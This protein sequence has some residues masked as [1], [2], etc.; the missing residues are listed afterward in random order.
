MNELELF[1]N[2]L[3]EKEVDKILIR[4]KNSSKN[5]NL[6]FKKIKLRQIFRK[7][8]TKTRKSLKNPFEYTLNKYK[9]SDYQK[10]SEKEFFQLMAN[11]ENSKI[12][13]YAR[14]ANALIY[15]NK[16]TKELLPQ[17]VDNYQKGRPLFYLEN[18]FSTK[19]D[20]QQYLIKKNSILG[21]NIFKFIKNHLSPE[22]ETIIDSLMTKVCEM[23]I[24]E[25]QDELMVDNIEYPSELLDY[26]YLL[27]HPEENIEVRM[28]LAAKITNY[29]INKQFENIKILKQSLNEDAESKEQ[30]QELI[31][32]IE[33]LKHQNKELKYENNEWKKKYSQS[34]KTISDECQKNEKLLYT[35]NLEKK[36]VINKYEQELLNYK[37]N[38]NANTN[39][40]KEEANKLQKENQYL[41]KVILSLS[42]E[43]AT[44]PSFAVIC[45][46][47]SM[48]E[49]VKEIYKEVLIFSS[50]DWEKQKEKFIQNNIKRIYIQRQGISTSTITKIENF[51]KKNNIANSLFLA[52]NS[53]NLIEQIGYFKINGGI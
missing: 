5:G 16:T 49:L 1:I 19:E 13:N 37:K 36:E 42:D 27:T 6:Q 12:T 25:L 20:V 9:N 50:E 22:E 52:S 3:D 41:K 2:L 24:L 51:S 21:A 53:K 23:D 10:L 11:P 39:I 17:L 15:F 43:Y 4:F 7:Q 8:T 32:Q 14:L 48:N 38:Y 47:K 44:Q 46:N 45:S 40:L 18:L 33:N 34:L 35:Y 30:V 29:L 26:A 31:Q 28:T